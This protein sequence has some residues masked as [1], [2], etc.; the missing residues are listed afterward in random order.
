M[1]ISRERK[2]DLKKRGKNILVYDLDN[3]PV[4]L[5]DARVWFN[6]EGEYFHPIEVDDKFC[7]FCTI[8]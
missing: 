2:F 8:S 1:F 3:K 5:S 6:D 7:N 4:K